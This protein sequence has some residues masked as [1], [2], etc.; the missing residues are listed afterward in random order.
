MIFLRYIPCIIFQTVIYFEIILIIICVQWPTF[1][2]CLQPLT[3]FKRSEDVNWNDVIFVLLWKH[4]PK[5]LKFGLKSLFLAVFSKLWGAAFHL[6]A[7]IEKD[8]RKI[9][10]Y[11][12]SAKI[13]A[14]FHSIIIMLFIILLTRSHS[15]IIISIVSKKVSGV[16]P[17][18]R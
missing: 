3:C 13:E 7:S 11:L 6:I 10:M 15:L 12:R 9:N 4:N 18:L 1:F 5:H 17:I 8:M 2:V 16:S 14:L